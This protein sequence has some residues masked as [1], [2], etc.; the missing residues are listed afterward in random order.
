MYG[1]ETESVNNSKSDITL[2][3]SR[4]RLGEKSLREFK[5]ALLGTV[6][7]VIDK[8]WKGIRPVG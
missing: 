3:Y 8:I 7:M 6:R 2:G 1:M 5:V 4:C